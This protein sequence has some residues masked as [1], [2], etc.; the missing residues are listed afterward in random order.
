MKAFCVTDAS[1]TPMPRITLFFLCNIPAAH[2]SDS[3]S[4]IWLQYVF[5]SLKFPQLCSQA[6][7]TLAVQPVVISTPGILTPFAI[8]SSV[9]LALLNWTN[10]ACDMIAN[11][12]L[13]SR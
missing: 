3:I 6:R 9:N 8:L 4:Q 13:K 1:L 5:S 2:C 12:P 11:A 7:L 10:N